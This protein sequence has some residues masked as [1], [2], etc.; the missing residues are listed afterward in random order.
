MNKESLLDVYIELEDREGL[1]TLFRKFESGTWIFQF[2]K[3]GKLIGQVCVSDENM[4]VIQNAPAV[5]DGDGKT[6][7]KA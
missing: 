2:N 3:D 1:Q 4:K 7:Q 6:K 5:K